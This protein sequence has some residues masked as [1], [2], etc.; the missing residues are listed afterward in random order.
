MI[1]SSN[2]IETS[3]GRGTLEFVVPHDHNKCQINSNVK[4]AFKEATTL[5][6][7]Q[8]KREKIYSEVPSFNVP[9]YSL[10]TFSNHII[11]STKPISVNSLKTF[12]KFWPIE[13]S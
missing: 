6:P 10:F 8:Q 2:T 1:G 12:I 4:S 13:N 11:L 7:T 9:T 3:F 5:P